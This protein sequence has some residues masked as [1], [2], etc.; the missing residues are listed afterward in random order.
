MLIM[1]WDSLFAD[2]NQLKI[3]NWLSFSYDSSPP[4]FISPTNDRDDATMAVLLSPVTQVK[5]GGLFAFVLAL[6]FDDSMDSSLAD[7]TNTVD[8]M[9]SSNEGQFILQFH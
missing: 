9:P 7:G 6:S 5:N 2:L 8:D 4:Y 1:D 3:P